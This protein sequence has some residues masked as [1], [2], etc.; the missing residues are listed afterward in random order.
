MKR[1]FLVMMQGTVINCVPVS[2][3]EAAAIDC[4]DTKV[5]AEACI[6]R[7]DVAAFLKHLT[8]NGIKPG[9]AILDFWVREA[10]TTGENGPRNPT[11]EAIEASKLP[12]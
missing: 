7:L 12:A 6:E 1:K 2:M 8:V 3:T 4:Y 11:K 5:E 10:W 9:E